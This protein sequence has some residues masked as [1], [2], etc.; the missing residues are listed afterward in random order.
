MKKPPKRIPV[1]AAKR[2]GEQYGQTQV[3]VLS[4]GPDGKTHAV[5]WGKTKVD[6][7]EAARGLQRILQLF[8]IS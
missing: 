6:C 3:L 8:G 1:A 4:F 5:S 7:K 2:Y